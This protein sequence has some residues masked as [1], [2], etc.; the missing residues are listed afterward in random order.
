MVAQSF[1]G[2]E[3]G[4]VGR[5]TLDVDVDVHVD[6][7]LSSCRLRSRQSISRSGADTSTGMTSPTVEGR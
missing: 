3:Y 1:A 4:G 7:V 2:E 6:L 5:W